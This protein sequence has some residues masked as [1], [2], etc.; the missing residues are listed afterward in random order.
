M[1]AQIDI[2]SIIQEFGPPAYENEKGKLSK[3]NESFWAQ[4]YA[5]QREK[6]IFEPNERAF[7][8]F[9]AT[10]GIFVPKSSDLIRKELSA[11]VLDGAQSW[12]GFKALEQFRSERNFAGAL[13]FLRGHVEERDFFNPPFHSVHLGNTT[14][15]FEP[16]GSKFTA[17]GFSP[18]H[19][20]RNR[21]PINYDPNAKCPEFENTILGHVCEGD[22]LLLQKYAGQC[23]LGRNLTQRFGILDGVGASSKGSFVLV[24]SGVIGP[25][26]VYELR[27]GMLAERFEIGRMIGRTL[28][29]GSDV[30]GNF[31]SQP[32][33]YRIKS[34]VGGDALE[35]ELKGSN[36]RFTVHG[37]FNLL[38]TSNARLRILLEGDRSAWERRVFIIRYDTPYTGKRIFE[39]EK[40]LLKIEAP[41]ILNWCIDGLRLLFQD[42]AQAGDIILTADQKARVDTLLSESDSLRIFVSNSIVKA[43]D[44]MT[45]GSNYSLTIEEIV[46]EYIDDCVN[47]KHWTPVP[48]DHAEK[49][50]PNLMLELFGVT[51]SHSVPRNGKAKRGFYS[52]RFV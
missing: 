14:L 33:A 13:A 10:A 6:I 16:D 17:E 43:P 4:Y 25:K 34:I 7:Y 28:L 27:T 5:Q 48:A 42:Y 36:K 29:V 44:P 24:I 51:K 31:L 20:S 50:V 11:L 19:R 49:R 26:N 37:I 1:N 8:D 40:H 3:L 46:N 22:R 18:K 39:I 45:N 41:G 35:A 2:Q 23:L 30:K 12:S 15:R 9:D 52:V 47:D 21:S 32:G 38:V